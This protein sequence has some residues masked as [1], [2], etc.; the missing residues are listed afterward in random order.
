MRFATE[1]LAA[2]PDYAPWSVRAMLLKPELEMVGHIR[3][4]SRPDPEYLHPYARDAIE[5]G[6][7]VFEPFRRRGFASE[8]A[9]GIMQWAAEQ[10]G[11]QRFIATVSPDNA[12]S[13]AVL[14]KLGFRKVGQ[15]ID[16]DDGPEDILL[17]DLG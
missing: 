11:V 10:H 6:F 13:Q 7:T 3:F 4:H 12:P 5:F 14:A 9:A 1:A 2:D 16:D 8:A 15:H 17:R